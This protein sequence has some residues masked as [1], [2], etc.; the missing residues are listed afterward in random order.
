MIEGYVEYPKRLY[1]REVKCPVQALLD[2]EQPGT[3]KHD[4]IRNVCKVGCLQTSHS[5]HAWL[6]ANGYLVVK[7]VES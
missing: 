5:F 3:P 2:A 1:C 4:E 6:N 7:P